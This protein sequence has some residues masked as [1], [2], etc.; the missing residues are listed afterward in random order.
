VASAIFDGAQ[1]RFALV[2]Y[3]SVVRVRDGRVSLESYYLGVRNKDAAAWC[4][5]DT[6]ALT[7]DMLHELYPG[8]PADLQLPPQAQAVIARDDTH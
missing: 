6:A 8:A 4:F 2:P 1:T 5:I 7:D 3:R